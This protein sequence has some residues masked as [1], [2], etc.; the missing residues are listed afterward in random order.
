[1]NV[2]EIPRCPDC[3]H[4]GDRIQVSP[5]ASVLTSDWRIVCA[6]CWRVWVQ[7]GDQIRLWWQGNPGAAFQ[8]DEGFEHPYP[9]D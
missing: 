7:R 1:M 6:R 9:F 4:A 2:A 5:H 3:D 8:V